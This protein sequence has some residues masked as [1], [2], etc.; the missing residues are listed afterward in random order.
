[1]KDESGR[2]SLSSAICQS[3][4]VALLAARRTGP[5]AKFGIAAITCSSV[6]SMPSFILHPSSFPK[7]P[8]LAEHLPQ[9]RQHVALDEDELVDA[10]GPPGGFAGAGVAG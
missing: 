6:G 2:L 9:G 5:S 3:A 8:L 7:H 10:R 4:T 1:M